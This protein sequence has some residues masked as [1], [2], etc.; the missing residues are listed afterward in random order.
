MKQLAVGVAR[1][2]G[3]QLV[4]PVEVRHQVR[5]RLLVD[6]SHRGFEFPKCL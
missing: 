6:C 2:L 3:G 5:L 1:Q 4:E